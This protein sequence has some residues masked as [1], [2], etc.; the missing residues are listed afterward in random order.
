MALS[1]EEQMAAVAS[2][3]PPAGIDVMQSW[4]PNDR[5]CCWQA[6][7]VTAHGSSIGCM[8]LREYVDFG[9]VRKVDF[10]RSWRED[11]LYGSLRS[12]KVD[13][14]CPSCAA[15]SNTGG[16]C[17][18]AAFAFTGR[19]TAPDPFCPTTNDGVDLRVLPQRLLPTDA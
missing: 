14:T 7:A 15:T 10:F 1:L 19:W 18:S 3:R 16:G 11:P 2:L 12:G 4:H 5:N 9:D 13:K 8:Y 6:A 17:R